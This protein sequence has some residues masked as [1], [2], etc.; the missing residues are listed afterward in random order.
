[1]IAS[2]LLLVL[3]MALAV[4]SALVV[5]YTAMAVLLDLIDKALTRYGKEL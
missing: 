2:L 3:F 1:M 5:G 4:A